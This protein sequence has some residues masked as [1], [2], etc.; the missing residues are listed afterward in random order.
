MNDQNYAP[1]PPTYPLCEHPVSLGYSYVCEL[2]N[3][4]EC[5]SYYK[6][7]A[8]AFQVL[9]YAIEWRREGGGYREGY[10]GGP[11][12][13]GGGFGRGGGGGGDKVCLPVFLPDT[14]AVSRPALPFTPL[15]L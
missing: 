15:D 8:L 14:Q 7:Y 5:Y 6:L 11:P 1:T 10:R 2:C 4:F 12:G 9:S 3:P 13:G